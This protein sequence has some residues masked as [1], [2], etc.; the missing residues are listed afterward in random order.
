MHQIK[1]S[2]EFK[3]SEYGCQSTR[4]QNFADSHWVGLVTS[5]GVESAEMVFS[6]KICP[7][8][9]G[10]YMLS[11]KLLVDVGVEIFAREN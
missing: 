11:Q 9:L 6:I 4:N 1:K 10:E 2:S 3:S 7:L 5:A 8:D